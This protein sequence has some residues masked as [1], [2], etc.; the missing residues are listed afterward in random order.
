MLLYTNPLEN[1]TCTCLKQLA[2][3]VYPVVFEGFQLIIKVNEK[4]VIYYHLFELIR[5]HFKSL[6]KHL[7]LN[8]R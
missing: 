1:R 5:K 6:D 2:I 4:K 3:I 7:N 8:Q